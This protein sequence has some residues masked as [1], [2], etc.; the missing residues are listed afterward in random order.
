MGGVSALLVLLITSALCA[1]ISPITTLSWTSDRHNAESIRAGQ[2]GSLYGDPL[3]SF[4]LVDPEDGAV[5][6]LPIEV[7]FRISA[8]NTEEYE[9]YYADA[10]FCVELNGLWKKC[11]APGGPPII[12]QLLPEGNY[13]TVA[14]ITDKSG[15]ARYHTT[16][17][18]TFTVLDSSAFNQRFG[19]LAERSRTEQHFP[20]D[21]HL[22]QW[23][24]QEQQVEIE[25][26]VDDNIVLPRSRGSQSSSPMLVV[27]V[28]TAVVTNFSRRQ[29]IRDTWANPATL[30]HDVKVLF[31]GCEP[32]LTEFKNE[33]DRR[34][35]LQ[36]ITKERA[37]YRDLLTEE[38]ECTDTYRGLA[39]KVKSFMHLA[40]A[41]FPHARF[42]T[43]ADDDIYLKIDQLAENLRKTTRPWLYFGE[44]WAEMFANRQRPIRDNE[45]QYHLPNDQYPMRELIPYVVGPHVVVS[46]EGVR[47]ISNNYW[48]LRSM[49]G[50]DDVSL[51]FWLRITQMDAQHA[52]EFSSGSA[53]STGTSSATG[54]SA[55]ASTPSR[56]ID[57]CIRSQT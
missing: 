30:P 36:A 52:P 12:F 11:K 19:E 6:M 9:A 43:I 21:I 31:L 38:L 57:T 55:T 54:A 41:E 48:R 53:R 56:G 3:T 14:Y 33:R 15:K 16:E 50:L 10:S 39:D 49:N 42:I 40:A 29:A 17:G 44:V 51:G 45:S 7:R 35:V 27:G 46:M 34:R 8:R 24:E 4:R 25:D 20:K 5:R 1:P 37:G 26:K 47:F 32:N 22:L 18:V 28:K 23:A 2:Y 13:T